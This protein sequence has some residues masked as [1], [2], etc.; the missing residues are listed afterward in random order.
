M[1]GPEYMS[2]DNISLAVAGSEKI[3][4]A[5]GL[6]RFLYARDASG[7]EQPGALVEMAMGET[8]DDF[9]PFPVGSKMIIPSGERPTRLRLQWA[10]QSGITRATFMWAAD[11]NRLDIDVKLRAQLVVGDLAIGLATAE[12]SVT[13]AA[14][15]IQAANGSRRALAVQ[16]IGG[17]D[18]YL[19]GSGV[20]AGAGYPLPAGGTYR[21][22]EFSGAIYGI[23]STGTVKVRALEE[24]N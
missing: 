7:S 5:A 23:V 4:L 16:N 18:V 12:V 24:T 14:T 1:L 9:L 20:T 10:A 6:F 11:P 19:G 13:T 3:D 15:L 8:T 17:A 21:T 22:A 2:F